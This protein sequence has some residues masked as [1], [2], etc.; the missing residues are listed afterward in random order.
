MIS[1][2][3][4]SCKLFIGHKTESKIL[5]ENNSLYISAYHD[6]WLQAYFLAFVCI[7]HKLVKIVYK[8]QRM[9]IHFFIGET[10]WMNIKAYLFA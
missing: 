5:I 8:K 3:P 4:I 7:I 10:L 9:K 1:A 6:I 2:C